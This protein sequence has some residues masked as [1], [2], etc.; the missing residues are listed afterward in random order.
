MITP[1]EIPVKNVTMKN[2]R[3]LFYAK[4]GNLIHFGTDIDQGVAFENFKKSVE[5]KEKKDDS[6]SC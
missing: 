2:G 1:V 4:F 6:G 3:F 5:T